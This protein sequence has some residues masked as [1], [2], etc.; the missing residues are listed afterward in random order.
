MRSYRS[1]T[2][3]TTQNNKE[4][5]VFVREGVLYGLMIEQAKDDT[6]SINRGIVSTPSIVYY[7]NNAKCLIDYSTQTN[8]D[9]DVKLQEYFSQLQ[10]GI[11]FTLYN[12]TYTD[13]NSNILADVSGSYT[14]R[15]YYNG[16]IEADVISV[17]SLSSTINRYDKN[18]FDQIPYILASSM[19]QGTE[20]KTI[21]KNKLGKN[22]R[23]SF[24]YLGVRVGD[25]IKLTDISSQL[26]I[27]EMSVD[28]D[29]NEYITVDKQLDSQDLTNIKTKVDVFYAVV[30]SYI[31][32][33]DVNETITGACIEYY[34]GVIIACT[35]NH[36]LSQCRFRSSAVN[37]IS[38]EITPNTFCSTPESDTSIQRSS[39]DSLVQLTTTLA[40][41]MANINTTSGVAGVVNKS[42]NTKNGFY[43]RPF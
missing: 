23:N 5:L 38:T 1:T 32:P 27:V 40:N 35:D 34:N 18:R 17:E 9:I 10:D 6:A 12:G 15:S 19:S 4:K 22:T 13:I 16:I 42:G 3:S 8:K 37:S 24:N 36:T 11:G 28:S 41:A 26:K 39:T 30:D 21:I 43:G 29:G 7:A 33:P 14:F 25:Y 2:T 20:I 31:S